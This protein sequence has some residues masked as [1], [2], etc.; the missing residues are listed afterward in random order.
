MPTISLNIESRTTIAPAQKGSPEYE[1]LHGQFHGE[2]DP[3]DTHNTIITDIEYAPRNTRGYVE[4]SATFAIAK[5]IDMQQVSGVLLYDV[6]NRGM[7]LDALSADPHGHMRVVS[8]W[9]SDL[10]SIPQLYTATVPIARKSNGESITSSTFAQFIDIPE[11]TLSIPLERKL[12]PLTIALPD[13]ASLDTRR[14]RLFYQ[15]SPVAEPI[16]IAP[17]D[18]AFADCR[19]ENFPGCPDAKYIS[20]RGGFIPNV[21][22]GLVY[23]AKDP[24]VQGIGF[25]ATRDLISFLR[26]AEDTSSAPNPL[27][28]KIRKAIAFGISQAGNFLKTGLHLGFNTDVHDRIVFDG[29]HLDIASRHVPLNVRFGVPGSLADHFDLGSEG[30]LWWS[31]YNDVARNVGVGSLLDRSNATET[32]PKIMETFGS[33]ELWHLRMSPAL[34]GT[35]ANDDLPLP[36]NVR[37]YYFPSVMHGSSWNSG[38]NGNSAHAAMLGSPLRLPGN[39]N[40]SGDTLR[41]LKKHFIDWVVDDKEPPP[42][43]YPRL[44]D[45]DLVQPT[46]AAM[47]WPAISNAPVPDGK[48][49]ALIEH[50]L[51]DTFC[52]ADTSGVVSLQPP[53]FHQIIPALVPRVNSDGNETAGVPSVQLL[54]PLGT[55][56]AWNEITSGFNQGRGFTLAGGFIPFAKTRA[57][58]HVNNDPRPSLTKRYGN[59]DGFV[60]RVRQVAKEQVEQGWLLPEDAERLIVQAE[61]SDVLI[62]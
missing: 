2:L 35:D 23:E 29:L 16:D 57:E 14:A 1:V 39:S 22:Y 24:K 5:P 11:G 3:T 45:G 26:Y 62:N 58:R 19:A 6:P 53:R 42:S 8:G 60:Q 46:A 28:G 51:G 59:H 47:G 17:D 55:Y 20:L 44:R 38:F 61:Q 54:V 9:Q 10:G 56:I 41:A 15:T 40:P 52:C 50:E 49:N 37:R 12:G 34:V 21:A 25:A 18:W 4:Y 33:A 36:A 31:A 48:L 30:I 32:C 13:S 7:H 27:A 43:R